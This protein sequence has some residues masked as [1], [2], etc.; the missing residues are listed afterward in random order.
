MKLPLVGLGSKECVF[1][2]DNGCEDGDVGCNNG[3]CSENSF[4]SSRFH[5]FPLY[6]FSLTSMISIYDGVTI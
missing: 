5:L 6:S 4:G 1:V 3:R 2:V